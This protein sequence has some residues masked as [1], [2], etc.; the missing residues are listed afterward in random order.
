M[1][2][3]SLLFKMLKFN[4]KKLFIENDSR[5]PFKNGSCPRG[6]VGKF[7]IAIHY[8]KRILKKTPNIT[9]IICLR[10]TCI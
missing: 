8:T 10:C 2:R 1:S 7:P 9:I 3:F 5:E 6:A 4:Q